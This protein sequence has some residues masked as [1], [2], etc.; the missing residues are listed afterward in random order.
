M[1][2]LSNLTALDISSTEF[3]EDLSVDK[4]YLYDNPAET[5]SKNFLFV[6]DDAYKLRQM[7]RNNAVASFFD[8]VLLGTSNFYPEQGLGLVNYHQ[9]RDIRNVIQFNSTPLMQ[10]K[11][12]YLYFAQGSLNASNIIGHYIRIYCSLSN[13]KSVDLV[14]MI[15]FLNDSNIKAKTSKIFESQIFNEAL[16]LTFPD[17]EFLVNSTNVE[18]QKIKQHIFGNDIPKTYFI[19]Y[20][21]ITQDNIDNFT[22]NGLQFTEVNLGV[23]NY[24]NFKITEEVSE[25]TAQVQLSDN[26]YALISY[27]QH[28]IYDIETYI[29]NNWQIN[30]ENFDISHIVTVTEYN[31]L[32]EQISSESTI[33]SNPTNEYNPVKIRPMLSVSTNHAMVEIMIKISNGA[34]GLT[35]SKSSTL[36]LTDLDVDKFKP[37]E[38]FS[39]NLEEIT[40]KNI[41]EKKINQI[42]PETSTPS[43]LYIQ[44]NIYVEVQPAENIEVVNADKYVKIQTTLDIKSPKLYLRIGDITIESEKDQQLVFR[45]PQ[46]IYYKSEANYLLLNDDFVLIQQGAIIRK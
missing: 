28:S 43:I 34:T 26:G 6:H 18:I 33:I 40:I 27:L 8:N 17:V 13:G 15:E 11:R 45:I 19:E 35:I 37:Q 5:T 29:N 46:S 41:V 14:N 30:D 10:Y 7:T 23:M 24:Q 39:L 32:D 36:L 12:A 38:T 21:V 42:V 22:E 31:G 3:V 44:K 16:E 9:N 25:L 1:I 20:S 2:R 4:L